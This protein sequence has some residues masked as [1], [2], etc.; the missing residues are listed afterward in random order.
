MKIKP[1][2]YKLHSGFTLV[3]LLVVITIIVVL[4]ALSFTMFPILRN[5]ADKATSI[6]NIGQLQF[7]NTTYAADHNGEY[8]KAYAFDDKGSTY[9]AWKDNSDFVAILKGE[10]KY[11]SNGKVDSSMPPNL[12][13]PKAYRA[14][15]QYYDNFTASYGYN[16][17]GTIGNN[18]WGSPNSTCGFRM[19]QLAAPERTAAFFSATDWLPKYSGRFFWKDKPV[20]G[21]QKGKIAYRYNNKALVAYY[22]GHV[23]EVSQS[24]MKAIDNQNGVKNTFWDAD[25]K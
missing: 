9:V 23:G 3:E 10:V 13:D 12:L 16:S 8:V 17:E 22:D 1:K 21:Y 24:D 18:G 19:D 20:E 15:G 2:S 25:G 14:K 11:L 4:A 5:S 6:R 7:A